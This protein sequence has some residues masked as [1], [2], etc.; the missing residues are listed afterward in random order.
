[1]NEKEKA[2]Q[3]LQEKI[4]RDGLKYAIDRMLL[5]CIKPKP[6]KNND[7]VIPSA[8]ELERMRDNIIKSLL[9]EDD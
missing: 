2:I 8:E 5:E 7:G 1:M 9:K 3:E 4:S 6:F